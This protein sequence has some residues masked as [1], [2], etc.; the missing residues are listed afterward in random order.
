VT[1]YE[2][3]DEWGDDRGER[4]G[5]KKSSELGF[6]IVGWMFGWIGFVIALCAGKR[7]DP[8]LKFWLNQMLVYDLARTLAFVVVIV[9][10]AVSGI[11]NV[12]YNGFDNVTY[13]LSLI[14][15]TYAGKLVAAIL[16]V[17]WLF[18]LVSICKGHRREVPIIGGIHIS[19]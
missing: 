11:V 18:G 8:F 19:D 3:R 13:L 14:L 9:L 1:D 10:M 17:I 15:Y 5:G 6:A 12:T 4:D 7:D 2:R 16:L